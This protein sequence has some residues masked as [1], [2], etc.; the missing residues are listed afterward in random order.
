MASTTYAVIAEVQPGKIP[1]PFVH[2]VTRPNPLPLKRKVKKYI[3][4]IMASDPR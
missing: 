4:N 3:M 1:L 2:N